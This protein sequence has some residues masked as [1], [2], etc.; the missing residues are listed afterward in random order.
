MQLRP[1]V[2][3]LLIPLLLLG[4][5][6]TASAAPEGAPPGWLQSPQEI[7]GL[8][9]GRTHHRER[10][11]GSTEIEYHARDGRVAYT[12]QGCTYAG[13]WWLEE[14]ILCYA[15]L[16][17]TGQVPHC[18]W[19]RQNRGQLEYWSVAEA[20]AQAPVAVTTDN[21]PGNPDHLP[22]DADGPCEEI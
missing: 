17:A 18:F 10:A 3:L 9:E 14:N 21:L 6:L 19:L 5:A 13:R 1:L 22:L 11:D 16:S 4:A 12:F 2:R 20:Q 8:V 7:A 15:Y